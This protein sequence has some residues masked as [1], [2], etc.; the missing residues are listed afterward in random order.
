MDPA[1]G[2]DLL[3]EHAH[4]DREIEALTRAVS[5]IG[6]LKRA[7][8]VF[9]IELLRHF[10]S[11][12]REL[13]IAYE[14]EEP[15]DAVVILGQHEAFRTLLRK[16]HLKVDQGAFGIDDLREIRIALTLHHAHEETGLY[17][18]ARSKPSGWTS[19]RRLVTA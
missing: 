17:P 18:W 9:E 3:I 14:R 13:L 1:F 7:F 10:A 15:Q 12:E 4:A 8:I 19:S 5:G 11:E 16:M 2:T 6:D